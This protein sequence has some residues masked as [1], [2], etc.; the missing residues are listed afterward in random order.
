MK[1]AEFS[2][3]NDK[4]RRAA[5]CIFFCPATQKFCLA[6]RSE[7]EVS[8]PNHWST[9]GGNTD[10]GESPEQT[11]LREIGEEAGYYGEIDLVPMLVNIDE[12]RGS[13]YFN[14]LAI[15]PNEFEPE[16]NWENSDYKWVSYGRWPDKLHPGVKELLNDEDSVELMQQYADR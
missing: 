5:G 4:K 14:F 2:P 11:V 15:V 3:R 7:R 12:D 8:Y 6:K 1:I 13:V 10:P 16:L 9:W